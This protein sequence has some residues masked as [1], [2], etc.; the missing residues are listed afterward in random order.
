MDLDRINYA[1]HGVVGAIYLRFTT[2]NDSDLFRRAAKLEFHVERLVL[3]YG[4]VNVGSH[5]GLEVTCGH[6]DFVV[7]RRQ[8]GNA[9]MPIRACGCVA[10]GVGGGIAHADGRILHHR[11]L[12]VGYCAFDRSSGLLSKDGNRTQPKQQTQN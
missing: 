1:R 11:T 9:I 7:P 12:R 8:F 4:Y 2:T 6:L 3:S 10:L 5:R